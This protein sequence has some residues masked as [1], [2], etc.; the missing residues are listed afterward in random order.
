MPVPPASIFAAAGLKAAGHVRWGTPVSETA[1]GLYVVALTDDADSVAGTRA[2]APLETR[3]LER[4]LLV[5]PDLQLDD[6]RPGAAD[7]ARRLSAFWLRQE[8]VVYIGLATSLR[9]RIGAYCRTP[10]GASRPHAGGWWL[11][12]LGALDELWVHYAPTPDFKR[13]ERQGLKA[14]EDGVSAGARA[15]L[16]DCERVMPFANLRGWDDRIKRHGI[17]S[18]TGDLPSGGR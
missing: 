10:L 14:F 16:H 15:A 6:H 2:E 18:A 7:L 4:L 17:A 3:Q 1:S 12:T 8:T 11:K 9:S 5:R 13:A